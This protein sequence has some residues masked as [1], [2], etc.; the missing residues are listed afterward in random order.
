VS[1]APAATNRPR[2]S[3][4]RSSVS[5]DAALDLVAFDGFEQRC[6]VPLTEALVALALNDFEEQGSNHG[7]RE[8]LQQQLF[9]R[10]SIRV[11]QELV[12]LHALQVFA[13]ARHALL[14]HFVI[15]IG[16]IEERYVAL[17]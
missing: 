14:D 1:H 10:L 17:S 6:E 15:R 8:D 4:S 16:R 11:D 12:L 3:G 7:L 13:V 5:K 9:L 2:L